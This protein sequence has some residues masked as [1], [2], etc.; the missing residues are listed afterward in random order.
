MRT[1][2]GVVIWVQWFDFSFGEE[3]FMRVRGLEMCTELRLEDI[4]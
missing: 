1:E 4:P 3:E 2:N